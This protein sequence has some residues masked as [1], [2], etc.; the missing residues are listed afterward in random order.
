MARKSDTAQSVLGAQIAVTSEV[1]RCQVAV[2]V[3]HTGVTEQRN[4]ETDTKHTKT[5]THTQNKELPKGF[6]A[7]FC[8]YLNGFLIL[9]TLS[10]GFGHELQ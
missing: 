8:A 4:S 10:S 6:H 2:H 3:N 7:C 1:V 5:H 9:T